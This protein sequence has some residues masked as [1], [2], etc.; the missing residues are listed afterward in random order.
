ME[1]LK[2]GLR[3]KWWEATKE[4]IAKTLANRSWVER[5]RRFESDV[6]EL[7]TEIERL[8]AL[9]KATDDNLTALQARETRQLDEVRGMRWLAER[10]D[11][12]E[13]IFRGIAREIWCSNAR[14]GTPTVLATSRADGTGSDAWKARCAA[15]KAICDE[16]KA[17]A[18]W[19]EVLDEETAEVCQ[20]TEPAKMRPELLQVAATAIRWH[21]ALDAREAVEA[22]QQ[23]SDPGPSIQVAPQPRL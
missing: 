21:L 8:R 11:I 23:E 13:P 9:V 2:C 4:R 19:G 14:F 15:A 1:E 6:A 18:S 7:V 22:T 17:D 16:K 3:P 10:L 12:A 5:G 20:E